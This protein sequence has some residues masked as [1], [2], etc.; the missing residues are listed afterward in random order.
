MKIIEL[1]S[2]KKTKE[3]TQMRKLEKKIFQPILLIIILFELHKC[4]CKAAGEVNKKIQNQSTTSFFKS[5]FWIFLKENYLFLF[6]CANRSFLRLISNSL[7]KLVFYWL[8]F[9]VVLVF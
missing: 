8:F 7:G 4:F 5:S 2:N 1:K 9:R 6:F 3:L